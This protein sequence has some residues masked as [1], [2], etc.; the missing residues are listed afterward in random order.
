MIYLAPPFGKRFFYC[1]IFNSKLL[2]LP[3]S[4][5]H[6]INHTCVALDNLHNLSRYVL[7][8]II[9]HRQSVIAIKV[10]LHRCIYSLQQ[11]FFVNA[12]EHKAAFV[13]RFRALRRGADAHRRERM[14]H[15]G[16]EAAFFRQALV[17]AAFSC[18]HMEDGDM[19][20]LQIAA[21]AYY[22]HAIDCCTNCLLS[23]SSVTRPKP[24]APTI[25][26]LDT[27][28]S[29]LIKCKICTL[30]RKVNFVSRF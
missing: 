20:A 10:H 30:F 23:C 3:F 15:T 26:S 29:H 18:F 7:I 28:K 25:R 6:L 16:E 12:C 1:T 8:Y 22:L 21:A 2:P 17:L 11:A 14:P 24:P 5:D 13:Q 27:N 9:R 4:P 19:Q